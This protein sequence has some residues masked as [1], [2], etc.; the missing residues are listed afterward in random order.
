[1][2]EVNKKRF[3]RRTSH[4]TLNIRVTWPDVAV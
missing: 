4:G 1:M 2:E 3:H